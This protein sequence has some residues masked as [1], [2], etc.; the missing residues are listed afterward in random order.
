M[1]DTYAGYADALNRQFVKSFEAQYKSG[2]K[3]Q[4]AKLLPCLNNIYRR[5]YYS[6]LLKDT[7]LTPA[8]LFEALNRNYSYYSDLSPTVYMRTP[9]KYTGLTF[10]MQSYNKNNHP[11]VADLRIIVDFCRP[12][13]G[14]TEAE[15]LT[16]K[17]AVEVAKSLHMNDPY[18]ATYLMS[19]AM[20]MGLIVKIP[21]IHANRYQL[22]SDIEDQMSLEDDAMFNKIVAFALRYA[23]HSLSDIVPLSTPLFDEDYLIQILKKPVETDVIF[24]RLYDVIGVDIEDFIGVDVFEEMDM[25]DMAVIS[26][27]Y[28]LGVVL[29]KFFLT[30]FGHYLKLIRPLYI[31][32]FDF[33]NEISVHLDANTSEDDLSMAFYAPCSR[34]YLTEM[35]LDFFG[36]KVTPDNYL[37]I[38]HKFPFSKIAPFF[39]NAPVKLSDVKAMSAAI[40]H[41]S[42]IYALKVKYLRD[43]KLWLNID[44]ADTTSLHRL[45]IEL[46]YYFDLDENA[47]YTLFIDDTE[48]P[49]TAYASPNQLNRANKTSDIALGDLSLQEKRVMVLSL[50]Y[51]KSKGLKHKSKWTLEVIRAHQGKPGCIYPMATRLGK[52]LQEHFEWS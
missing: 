30:P 17:S 33:E 34:Y 13:I 10:S 16:D 18:Y 35:G 20:Q 5:W 50:N 47:E 39:D 2:N 23:S 36:V 19:L 15:Q 21:S 27:T 9:V 12:D 3:C 52:A 25:L 38:E 37:D 44:A 4:R 51:P 26:G 28:L 42:C 11:V 1:K 29:D 40:G 14:L 32:P 46:C 41:E 24:K 48:N 7:C 22:V 45:Y 31:F 6:S 49:F 43:S 8:N